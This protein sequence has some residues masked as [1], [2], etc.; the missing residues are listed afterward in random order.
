MNK[1]LI[2]FYLFA[3]FFLSDFV[4]YAQ[5]GEDDDNGGLDDTD[6]APAPINSKIIVLFLVG[7]LFAFY[8][9]R[10]NKKAIQ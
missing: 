5:P 8:T 1:K 3:F 10:R 6:P 2:Y 9:Y 4:V 7:I